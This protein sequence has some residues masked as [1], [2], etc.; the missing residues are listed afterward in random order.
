[1]WKSAAMIMSTLVLRNVIVQGMN[2]QLRTNFTFILKPFIDTAQR[3]S[4]YVMVGCPSVCLSVPLT[5]SSISFATTQ[6][7][8]AEVAPYIDRYTPAASEHSSE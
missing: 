6:T 1:M 4:V 3:W 8:A 7:A 5:D 2:K